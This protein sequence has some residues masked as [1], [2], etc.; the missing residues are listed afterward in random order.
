MG[1]CKIVGGVVGGPPVGTGVRDVVRPPGL[2][3]DVPLN[4]KRIIVV[5]G[6]C[7][8]AL[9]PLAAVDEG[10]LIECERGDIV[11]VF[12]SGMMASGCSRGSRTTLA[13]GVVFQ[14]P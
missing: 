2:V 11:F 1:R 10:D 3:A 6:A 14:R 5:P 13:I 8:V 4:R 9:L 12:R 7:E